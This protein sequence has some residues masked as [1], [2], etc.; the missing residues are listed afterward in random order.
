MPFGCNLWYKTCHFLHDEKVGDAPRPSYYVSILYWVMGMYFATHDLEKRKLN[1][2]VGQ[3]SEK[4]AALGSHDQTMAA[5]TM[6]IS[7][8]VG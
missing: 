4:T 3:N 8:D 5:I 2:T 6:V 7:Q 1:I